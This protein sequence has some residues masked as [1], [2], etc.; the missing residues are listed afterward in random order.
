MHI[1]DAEAFAPVLCHPSVMYRPQLSHCLWI[2]LSFGRL[3]TF[4]ITMSSW[5]PAVRPFTELEQSGA[6]RSL[7]LGRG[8]WSHS[9]G[10]DSTSGDRILITEATLTGWT[11]QYGGWG[12]G[13]ALPPPPPHTPLRFQT[14][15]L[16]LFWEGHLGQKRTALLSDPRRTS[17]ER[18][19]ASGEEQT[20]L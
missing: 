16:K 6:R 18:R 9:D 8:Y 13:F 19:G 14:D 1:P 15:V 20:R 3:W 5:A 2:R 7:P 11:R 17:Q 4:P 12:S 10:I